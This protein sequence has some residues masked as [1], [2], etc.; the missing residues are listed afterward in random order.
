MEKSE[1]R[2][3]KTLM[4]KELNLNVIQNEMENKQAVTSVSFFRAKVENCRILKVKA[5][6][7]R[8]MSS[9]FRLKA[10]DDPCF[11]LYM[12]EICY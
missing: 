8:C 3:G 6:K 12:T 4:T 7:F 1:A 2:P 9:T 11:M 10:V 5:L